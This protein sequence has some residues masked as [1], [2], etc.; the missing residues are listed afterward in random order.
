M[1]NY[2]F[3]IAF[4]AFIAV[5][6]AQES[7]VLTLKKAQEQVRNNAPI[8][9][10][11]AY[12]D[13]ISIANQSI[14]AK[15]KLPKLSLEALGQ[16][17]TENISIGGNGLPIDVSL[18]LESYRAYLQATIPIYDGGIK[19][20][21]KNIDF[22]VTERNQAQ[23]EVQLQN[24]KIQVNQ[25]FFLILAT[26]N[27]LE[28]LQPNINTLES[29]IAFMEARYRNG[30]LLESELLQ[31][32]IKKESLLAQQEQG[33]GTIA[34]AMEALNV[35]MGSSYTA[36][37]ALLVNQDLSSLE[38]TNTIDRPE[39]QMYKAQQNVFAAQMD[40][41]S[42]ENNPK[43]SL[44]GQGGVGYPNPLNFPDVSTALYGIVGVQLQW[45]ILQWGIQER[46]KEKLRLET[47]QANIDIAQFELGV[48][49]QLKNYEALQKS[50]QIEI[51]KYARIINMQ[52]KV[53]QQTQ[54]QL[55]NGVITSNDY[56]QQ[57]NLAINYQKERALLETKV[58]RTKID[59]LTILGKI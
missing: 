23:N 43:L 1:R 49:A 25:L 29:T 36:N 45:P 42:N 27:Q 2:L 33:N 35:L 54:S 8:L 34:G 17:Q 47:E 6:P 57:V 9:L 5:L 14:L 39:I 56:L 16:Y 52:E 46:K 41:V 4:V 50:L 7:A 12:L 38:V 18:P 31:I 51:E 59:M 20:A 13:S 3:C 28:V 55:K 48:R 53:V 26:R 40:G 11:K 22:A 30:A 44:F 58:L 32:Q 10:K 24:L 37:T 21:N 19:N 15:E